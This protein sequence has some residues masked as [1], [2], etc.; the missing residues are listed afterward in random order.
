MYIFLNLTFKGLKITQATWVT[1]VTLGDLGYLGDYRARLS[2][3]NL[4]ATW[5]PSFHF[6]S[7]GQV[8]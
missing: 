7:P 6:W 2:E 1:R 5:P 8:F 3:K 4:G